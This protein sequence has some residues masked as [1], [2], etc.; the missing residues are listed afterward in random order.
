[1]LDNN[2]TLANA[3][4][5][6]VIFKSY[7]DREKAKGQDLISIL[8]HIQGKLNDLPD[9]RGIVLVPPPIQG[10][11]QAGGFQMEVE[12][13]GG[14]FNYTKLDELTQQ[15]VKSGQRRSPSAAGADDLPSECAA[16]RR[17]RGSRPSGDAQSL[18]RRRILDAVG[19]SRLDLHQPVQQIRPVV[20]GLCA[21]RIRNFACSPKDILNLYVR[22]SDQQMVPIS[23]VA[24]LGHEVAPPL[25]TLY[26]LFPSATVVGAPAKGFSSG[27]SLAAMEQI[28]KATLPKR[29]RD[30]WSGMSYQEKLV[31]NQ[32][33]L[34]FRPLDPACLS[35][36]RRT[37]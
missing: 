21:G 10:I 36:P 31:G 7:A 30:E 2:A 35:R 32:L 29:C 11:G 15:I 1:M 3:G 13:L 5:E 26:N 24:Y 6:Y 14:S 9:G 12:M 34:Y 16:C 25:I 33:D 20:P 18:G 28:A 17:H 4:V 37:I 19:L 23:S 8:E 27:Q 22:N